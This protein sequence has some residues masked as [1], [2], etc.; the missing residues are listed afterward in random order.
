MPASPS[1]PLRSHADGATRVAAWSVRLLGTFEVRHP[2]GASVRLPTRAAM[3]LLARLLLAPDR[4]H[5]REELVELLWPGVAPEAGRNR[6]RQVLSTLKRQ[7]ETGFTEPLIRAERL[8]LQWVGGAL[9]CDVRDFER[10]LRA[11]DWDAAEAVYRG[12]LLPGYYDEWVIEERARLAALA[13]RLQTMP[14][15]AATHRPPAPTQAPGGLPSFWTRLFGAELNASRLRD[16]VRAHRLVTVLGA[17]G[18]GK[19]RLAVEAARALAEHDAWPTP[20]DQ[21]GTRFDPIV[22]VSLVDCKDAAR[23]L[24][25]MAAALR[26]QGRDP[27]KD[28]VAA[29]AG[30]RSLLVLDNFEQL[31]GQADEPLQKLLLESPHLHLMITSRQRLGVAGEHVFELAGLPLAGGPA[32]PDQP[33]VALFMDRARA[34]A[35]DFSLAGHE[36]VVAELVRLLA[37]MPLAIELAASRMRGLSPSGLLALLSE[38][39]QPMLDLLAREGKSPNMASRHASMR[40]VVDWSWRQLGPELCT[41][42]QA[43]ATFAA[44][45]GCDT[46]AYVAQLASRTARDRL[47]QL[48]DHSLVVA[49]RGAEG[50]SRYVLLQPV[51]EFVIERTPQAFAAELRARLRHWLLGFAWQCAAR[52][53]AAI[54]DVEAEM[55]QVQAAILEAVHDGPAAQQQAVQIAVALRRHWE[56]D[57]RAGLPLAMVQALDACLPAVA[58][59]GLRSEACALQAFSKILAGRSDEALAQVEEAV[60]VAPDARRLAQAQMRQ[61]HVMMFSR[62]DQSRVDAPLAQ[63]MAL[64]R[65]VGDRETLALALRMRYLVLG[66]RDDDWV[67]SEHVA[68]EVQQIW[69]ELGHRRNAYGAL[70]DRASC[71]MK[72]GRVEEAAV[73]FA[74]CERVAGQEGFATGAIMSSWQL[75][76]AQLRLRQPGAA[77]ASFR[78]CLSGSWENK[79][80]AYVADALVQLPGGLAFTG[81]AEDA[82]R[83][84]GFA[85]AHWQRQFGP[86][87]RDMER[88]VRPTRRWLLHRLG[89]ARHETLRVEGVCL[90]LPEAVALGLGHS[91]APLASGQS[92]L[93]PEP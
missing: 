89:A 43:L 9:A 37:G 60:R 33:A 93:A 84:L 5:P 64:A 4:L 42:M 17:G 67:G 41:L 52:A 15:V 73:A 74:A 86:F 66:N 76:R 7:L 83:L 44:P 90:T 40:H 19:T 16:A 32:A 80:L 53:H 20:V 27:S 92:R 91:S 8:G 82:A 38:R 54:D 61:V 59:A 50:A 79:R 65:Q 13:E 2:T 12:E 45:A 26:L 10:H 18:S 39:G 34:V 78:R 87:Y 25:A 29:L 77:L 55:H 47:E 49:H 71:W 81:Q 62:G 63:A 88:D 11:G 58:E 31:V 23:A 35:P 14:R 57:T 28:I 46:V 30:R 72:A 68:L 24:D 75:G 1:F 85:T 22:F 56:V 3:L 36:A 48:R 21:E 51:R 6:L 70:M 69:E